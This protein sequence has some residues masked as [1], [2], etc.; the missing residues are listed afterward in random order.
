MSSGIFHFLLDVRARFRG[1]L[2]LNVHINDRCN[3][4]CIMCDTR[5]YYEENLGE[6]INP[7][8]LIQQ[9]K[10]LKRHGLIGVVIGGTEP[11]LRP[12]ICEILHK[13]QRIGV[14]PV[15]ITNGTLLDEEMSKTLTRAGTEIV[16]S[17]DGATPKTNDRIRGTGTFKQIVNGISKLVACRRKTFKTHVLI[18]TCI[19]S[20]NLHEIEAIIKLG[21]KIGVDGVLF[22]NVDTNERWLKPDKEKLAAILSKINCE[23]TTY[24]IRIPPAL[25]L[26][27]MATEDELASQCFVPGLISN[28]DAYGNV[29]GCWRIKK[30]LGNIKE[31]SFL[32]IWASKK[33]RKFRENVRLKR[34]AVCKDCGLLCYTPFNLIFNNLLRHPVRTVELIR[35]FFLEM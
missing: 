32:N 6:V 17:L 30:I 16:V 1:P 13:I 21:E 29:F 7:D 34:F 18:N 8:D 5:T 2:F 25:Y 9:L 31:T 19:T 27:S 3:L 20:I 12:D 23:R 10:V 35:G 33:Y 24:K 22:Q 28:V 26:Q 15:L 11:L 4:K 14:K